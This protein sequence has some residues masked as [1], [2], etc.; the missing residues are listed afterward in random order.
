MFRDLI[1]FL[2][3]LVV[4]VSARLFYRFRV[5]WL[6]RPTAED[7]DQLR[8][9][10]VLHHTSLM[11]V[12][13]FGLIPTRVLWRM[14]RNGL[15]PVAQK[16]LDRPWLGRLFGSMQKNVVGLTRKRDHTWRELLD[17]INPETLMIIVPE[18]RMMRRDGLDRKGH[19]MTLRGGVAEVLQAMPVGRMLVIYSGGMHHVQ[20]PGEDRFPKLFR[21]IYS[22]CEML[23]LATYRR[24][25]LQESLDASE[26]FRDTVIK[27]LSARR[28]RHC[29]P[30]GFPPQELP[31]DRRRGG[32]GRPPGP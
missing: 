29:P 32:S 5:D 24:D 11:E 6:R 7:W 16:T 21:N 14:A 30:T 12:V 17:K 4:K 31:S 28:N 23:D 13:Y 18:G 8:L 20:I 15:A 3:L 25:C 19:P 1:V 26:T 9:L 2:I 27:D 10:V 22:R